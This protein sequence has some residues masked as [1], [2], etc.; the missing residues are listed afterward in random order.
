[1]EA[2]GPVSGFFLLGVEFV[3][4]KLPAVFWRENYLAEFCFF[5]SAISCQAFASRDRVFTAVFPRLLLEESAFDLRRFVPEMLQAIE[6]PGRVFGEGFGRCC[7]AAFFGQP[8]LTVI[9]VLLACSGVKMG[10]LDTAAPM[11]HVKDELVFRDGPSAHFVG[12]A[13]GFE[14]SAVQPD[15]SVAVRIQPVS[16]DETWAIEGYRV[17]CGRCVDGGIV[18]LVDGTCGSSRVGYA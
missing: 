8:C 12:D 13:V 9:G 17:I 18:R 10:G 1:M 15:C 16:P 4:E 11:A 6:H 14:G 3:E 7:P 5:D 2:L